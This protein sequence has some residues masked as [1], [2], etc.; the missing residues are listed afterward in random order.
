ME[1]MGFFAASTGLNCTGCHVSE[2]LQDWSKFAEDIPRK[3][4]TRF[5][6]T[7]VNN[8]NKTSFGGRK[9]VTCYTC[10]HAG[11]TPDAIPSL[12]DQYN[13]EPEDANKIEIPARPAAGP[14]VDA[15]LDKYVQALG[16]AQKVAALTSLVEKGTIE[17]FDTYH[18]PV[19]VEIYATPG[20][21]MRLS[22]T[23]VGDGTYTYDGKEAW[24]AALDRP[25]PLIQL[26]A[27]ELDAAKFDA[28]VAF[29]VNLKNALTDWKNGFPI[30]T[31]DD[32]D[33]NVIQGMG[34]GKSRFKLFFD[35]KTG[36]L[37]R[38]LHYQDTI[39]GTVPIQTDF[40]DYR[41]VAGVKVPYDV[42]I[43][44]TDGQWKLK[45]TDVQANVPVDAAKFAKPAPAKAKVGAP[46]PQ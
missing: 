30:T 9:R 29:P 35:E 11:A 28:D 40:A 17:G 26:F 46:K 12:A 6:I 44:W 1:T 27:A 36:L 10:H 15:L 18:V 2:S 13:V 43:T 25:V 14:T 24:V 21:R 33:V 31:I 3:R 16:G 20:K 42:V 37:T 41:E 4:M 19:P 34:A 32:K 22:H 39:V 5:M 7:M 23:Q 38:Y 45:L 8:I